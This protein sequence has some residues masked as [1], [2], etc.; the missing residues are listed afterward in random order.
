MSGRSQIFSTLFVPPPQPPATGRGPQCGLIEVGPAQVIT[1]ESKGASPLQRFDVIVVGG[2]PAGATAARRCARGSLKTLLMEKEKIPRY[3]PCGGG[4]TQ[5]A[6]D[7]LDFPLPASV[8]ERK[9][10][11]MRVRFGKITNCV[12]VERTIAYMVTRSR[13]DS[14]L[15]EKAAEAGALV[16]D[17]ETCA[18]VEAD[19]SGVTVRAPRDEYR[20]NLVVGAD[21][22]YG[23]V[24]RSLGRKFEKD[25]VRF[26][27]AVDVPI[28]GRGKDRMLGDVL[29]IQYGSIRAGYTWLFPKSEY[30][31]VGSAGHLGQSVEILRELRRFLEER[32]IGDGLKIRG[33]LLPV[34]ALRG[35]VYADRVL[36]AGDAAGFVDSFS[37]EGIRYAIASGGFAAR[38]AV[39]CH[40]R[41]D[42]SAGMLRRYHDLCMERFAKDLLRSA[43]LTDKIFR[44]PGL[45][46]G[47]A[48]ASE[49][50]IR[51]YLMTFTGES[52]FSEYA[53]WMKSRLP[54]FLLYRVFSLGIKVP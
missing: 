10:R 17:G 50:I 45:F 49:R 54:L 22:Y 15:V 37:G 32:G 5:A 24:L 21:G 4:V 14:F 51:R 33:C 27:A 2:G 38:A 6:V 47:T 11:G 36:F 34:S 29:E 25:E 31:S 23:R 1:E 18:A 12:E 26:C 3:K 44:H 19:E 16:H 43:R 13:F 7:E 53:D 42:F 46:L 41:N 28:R 8:V 9:C 40:E 52:S 35:G 39:S 48:I 20:A 30:L